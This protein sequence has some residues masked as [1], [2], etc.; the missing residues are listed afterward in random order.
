MPKLS[1]SATARPPRCARM[2]SGKPM[3]VKTS[4][5]TGSAKRLCSST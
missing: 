4:A 2:P 3:I 5:A 1:A